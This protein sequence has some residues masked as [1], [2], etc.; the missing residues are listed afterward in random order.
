M[1]H[2]GTLGDGAMV[3]SAHFGGCSSPESWHDPSSGTL[4]IVPPS[5]EL[6]PVEARRGLF[7]RRDRPAARALNR[8]VERVFN[9]DKRPALGTAEA[10]AGS[11][12]RDLK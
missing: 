12:T 5:P 9:P 7:V 3:N 1:G 2:Y 11:V 10:G 8:N 4:A 6:D